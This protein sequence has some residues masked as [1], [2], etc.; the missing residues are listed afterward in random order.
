VIGRLLSRVSRVVVLGLVPT[1][2]VIGAGAHP[3]AADT[4]VFLENQNS[5]CA[6][7]VANG[8]VMQVCDF[9]G[10]AFMWKEVGIPNKPGE[11]LL[12]SVA[13]GNCLDIVNHDP[14]SGAQVDQRDCVF[15]GS[16]K[17]QDWHLENGF[18]TGHELANEGNGT[19]LVMHPSGCSAQ[20]GVLLFM[21]E[22]DSC[23]ADD[24]LI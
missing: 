24:W 11:F 8:P 2:L 16:Q 10:T 13:N 14:K 5:K 3:A 20:N 22:R 19:D 7:E 6:E 1:L 17:F 15:D 18:H 12:R 9:A 21:N 4:V 23:N